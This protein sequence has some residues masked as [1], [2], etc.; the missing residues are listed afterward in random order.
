MSSE[1]TNQSLDV[2][3][4][5]CTGVTLERLLQPA[6]LTVLSEGAL[7]GYGLAE[8]ISAMPLLGG[9]KPDASGIYRFLKAMQRKGLVTSSW[10][11]SQNGPAKRT[12]QLTDTGECCLRTWI[13]TLEEYRDSI[14]SLLRAARNVA[15]K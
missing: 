13:K 6:I 9:Q 11:T 1:G 2:L 7:H 5:T 3:D 10:D 8:R 15:G 14:N 4:C 12:Y